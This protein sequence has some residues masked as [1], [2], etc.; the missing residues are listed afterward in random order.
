VKLTNDRVTLDQ[1]GVAPAQADVFGRA[2]LSAAIDMRDC[3]P[4]CMLHALCSI[5]GAP[6]ASAKRPS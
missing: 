5:D 6:T 2:D 3:R 4:E 1:L